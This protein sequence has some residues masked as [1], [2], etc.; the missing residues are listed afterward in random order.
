MIIAD[1]IN[2]IER[3]GGGES[4]NFSIQVSRKAFQILSDLYSN[5]YLAIVR[6]LGC[7][8]VDSH[9]AAGKKDVPIYIHLPNTFEPYL[10]IRDFGTGI[11]QDD[12]FS[13]YSSYFTSTKS[14]SNDAIGCLGLGSKSPFCYTDNF[15]VTSRYGGTKT[16]YLAYFDQSGAPTLTIASEE[17]DNE[18]NGV[19][20]QIPVKDSDFQQFE[21]AAKSAFRWFDVKPNIV[22]CVIDWDKE[23]GNVI[24]S[25]KDWFLLERES[26]VRYSTA[27]S[28]NYAI[29]GGV[30]YPINLSSVYEGGNND[31]QLENCVIRFDIGELDVTPSRES[32]SY[33][34]RTIE[35]IKAKLSIVSQEICEVTNKAILDCKFIDEAAR[36][37]YGLPI[38]LQNII[39]RFTWKGKVAEVIS[40]EDT[41]KYFR[42]H[43][44]KT[45]KRQVSN[46]FFASD[47]YN[48]DF[49]YNDGK[50]ADIYKV[51][52]Y[53]NEL[54]SKKT[55]YQTVKVIVIDKSQLS[56]LIAL[57][58][59]ENT[60]K[61]ISQ[62][63][64][65]RKAITRSSSGAS[66]T[67][68]HVSI[69]RNNYIV[70]ILISD[71]INDGY[72]FYAV[73]SKENKGEVIVKGR[74]INIS[75][76][77]Y[78]SIKSEI[79]K[80]CIFIPESKKKN[81]EAAGM[82]S[83]DVFFDD[84][85]SIYNS[86]EGKELV[87]L[88]RSGIGFTSVNYSAYDAFKKAIEDNKCDKNNPLYVFVSKLL[89][90]CKLKN[91][92]S[93]TFSLYLKFNDIEVKE[94][95]MINDSKMTHNEKLIAYY[96]TGEFRCYNN[97]ID[98]HFVKSFIEL[99]KDKDV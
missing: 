2:Q 77:D 78:L 27:R 38:Y 1:K 64:Y 86:G 34:D 68:N 30:N 33:D 9:A 70:P 67:N 13:I 98:E 22:N 97:S 17:E 20:I 25:G 50:R 35:N 47:F 57:G 6:E 14:K 41:C 36:V 71:A 42:L 95:S 65:T 46:S 75:G 18:G 23:K 91:K 61:P 49:F 15:T 44:H 32:I 62:L 52:E 93:D 66:Y 8:A 73:K 81:V 11:S 54:H 69:I 21:S 60:I 79:I 45:V 59:N 63:Q 28:G 5:K 51:R 99:V 29:M 94:A 37:Y 88:I 87:D 48:T 89:R 72:K 53:V 24:L 4:R 74:S 92:M 43:Y 16:V 7:N 3:I 10:E 55:H 39:G 90:V 40:A 19:S 58:V 83:I 31:C 26:N 85:F 80:K 96:F 84:M 76:Y 12:I 56:E 82:Q